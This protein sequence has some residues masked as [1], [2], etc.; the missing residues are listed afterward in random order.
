MYFITFFILDALAEI[1]YSI[2]N[3][4]NYLSPAN[5]QECQNIVLMENQNFYLELDK[6]ANI[7]YRFSNDFQEL[8]SDKWNLT[9]IEFVSQVEFAPDY[10]S[11]LQSEYLLFDDGMCFCSLLQNQRNLDY[12]IYCKDVMVQK[13]IGYQVQFSEI[14][15]FSFL[16]LY[17]DGLKCNSFVFLNQ[18]F[19][20]LC[21][22]EDQMQIITF[23]LEGNRYQQNYT[24]SSQQ[25]E[26]KYQIIQRFSLLIAFYKCVNWEIMIYDHKLQDLIR[27]TDQEIYL[28]A[29][30]DSNKYLQDIFI[31]QDNLFLIFDHEYFQLRILSFQSPINS[32]DSTIHIEKIKN[33]Q[34]MLLSS[35]TLENKI[36]SEYTIH[37]TL[38]DFELINLKSI[39]K[40]GRY[41]TFLIYSDHLIV[42][43]T[44]EITQQIHIE[45]NQFCYIQQKLN[46]FVIVDKQNKVNLFEINLFQNYF[47]YQSNI[48]Y[49]GF[50]KIEDQIVKLI[51][52]F[53]INQY[54]HQEDKL[55][56]SIENLKNYNYM[57]QIDDNFDN[58]EIEKSHFFLNP[59]QKFHFNFPNIFYQ[60]IE[61]TKNNQIC[62]INRQQLKHAS[63]F[64]IFKIN[65]QNYLM[66]NRNELLVIY[67]CNSQ[68][69]SYFNLKIDLNLIKIF[70]IQNVQLALV[71][72]TEGRIITF[73]LYQ[74]LYDSIPYQMQ[75]F[76]EQIRVSLLYRNYLIILLQNSNQLFFQYLK[77]N[78]F[79]NQSHYNPHYFNNNTDF[80]EKIK[81]TIKIL[82]FY[83]IFILQY[84]SHLIVQVEQFVFQTINLKMVLLGG[85]QK[86]SQPLQIILIGMNQ[87]MNRI[88]KY[89]ITKENYYKISTFYFQDYIP[90]QPLEYQFHENNLIITT[91]TQN[92]DLFHIMIFFIDQKNNLEYYEIISTP[93]KYFYA[94]SDFLYYYNTNQ[95]L[96]EYN[97]K[98]FTLD[99]CLQ[100]FNQIIYNL[101][102]Q[103][104]II[105]PYSQID[106]S[107][108]SEQLNLFVINYKENLQLI[109]KSNPKIMLNNNQAIINP[110]KFV[111]GIFYEFY[112]Q[113]TTSFILQSPFKVV[114][115][116]K[117]LDLY[118]NLCV[119]QFD[120]QFIVQDI[121]KN[122]EQNQTFSIRI[123]EDFK[124][125]GCNEG[126]IITQQIDIENIKIQYFKKD[127]EIFILIKGK[128]KE[129][130]IKQQILIVQTS[131][132]I[133]YYFIN[134]EITF[135][136]SCAFNLITQYHNLFHQID[137]DKIC[138]TLFEFNEIQILCSQIQQGVKLSIQNY[139]IPIQDIYDSIN[140]G[141]PYFQ[142][143]AKIKILSLI[144]TLQNVLDLKIVINYI[145]QQQR[146]G[147]ILQFHVQ[148]TLQNQEYQIILTNLIRLP[149]FNLNC[150]LQLLQDNLLFIC[151][152]LKIYLYKLQDEFQVLDPYAIQQFP[153]QL[154]SILNNTHIA[155]YNQI[156]NEVNI[157][158]IDFWR[159]IKNDNIIIEDEQ[160]VTFIL[161][162]YLTQL[163]L[164]V[165]VVN[166]RKFENYL[167]FIRFIIIIIINSLFIQIFISVKKQNRK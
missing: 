158:N 90:I 59:N 133:Y 3:Q 16:I 14:Q 18:L 149:K 111:H 15:E 146:Y 107:N 98:Y 85:F 135:I 13:Y 80:Q 83:N 128:L 103:I 140:L 156:N 122:V 8:F 72:E 154:F 102:F 152:Q 126:I 2:P 145:R 31:C 30:S 161:Q 57:I 9:F 141:H 92:Q 35:C 36:I 99:Y 20:L 84:E 155:I 129:T 66:F 124:I 76:K 123:T 87:E 48:K 117:C 56:T 130:Q 75:Q 68:D 54:Q 163:E 127:I 69:F 106:N 137:T 115:Q 142:N 41:L 120:P 121:T 114:S 136:Y 110:N 89:L 167:T 153:G 52:C 1:L 4:N 62:N 33:L 164:K 94:I 21:I 150:L 116:K 95:E 104:D 119:I 53:V 17:Q 37:S 143:D 49:V 93:Y 45:I 166:Q 60:R 159:L 118:N 58:I 86:R 67:H 19:Y 50:Y 157:L 109:N 112:L 26:V 74:K 39:M 88:D 70:Y 12:S 22:I 64:L 40:L 144:S 34:F 132:F 65:L 79:I 55:K 162:N 47:I 25:C 38:I 6:E 77:E 100:D 131:E 148:I 29:Q 42:R 11:I 97:I 113:N 139:T 125:H 5:E 160:N 44:K 151:Q 101:Q 78:T 23:D 108:Y 43:L 138:Q 10:F 32:I 63:K 147:Q 91:K 134:E 46:Y 71:Q 7:F 105:N 81:N 27:I 165:N 61:H 82:N 51:K 73:L 96:I 28:K 24:I